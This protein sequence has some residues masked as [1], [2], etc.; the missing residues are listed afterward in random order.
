MAPHTSAIRRLLRAAVLLVA[1][2]PLAGRAQ[3]APGSSG[4]TTSTTTSQVVTSTTTNTLTL[5]RDQTFVIS[6]SNIN[7]NGTLTIPGAPLGGITAVDVDNTNSSGTS[8]SVTSSDSP[9]VQGLVLNPNLNAT[10]RDPQVDFDLAVTQATPGLTQASRST[11][12]STTTQTQS[13]L[14]VFTAPFVP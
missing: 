1:I 9:P 14:S 11:T 2:T 3:V 13:S 8:I 5:S 7:I 6:G 12:E 10:V 4:A